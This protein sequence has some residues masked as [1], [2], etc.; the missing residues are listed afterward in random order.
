MHASG[1]LGGQ[2]GLPGTVEAHVSVEGVPE[3]VWKKVQTV[4]E[5]GGGLEELKTKV[6]VHP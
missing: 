3:S 5:G 2:V 6:G 4:K 1:Y